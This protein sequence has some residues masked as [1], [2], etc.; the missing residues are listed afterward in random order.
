MDVA[1]LVVVALG[2]L[3]VPGLVHRVVLGLGATD[4]HEV[5][6]L[7]DR[8]SVCGRVWNRDAAGREFSRAEIRTRSGVEPTLV[9]PLPFAPCP[10]GPCAQTGNG[11]CDT[12]V[13]VRV[14]SDAYVDYS[15]SGGP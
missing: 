13:Y 2:L 8:I 9:D 1:A 7:P 14:G 11:S 6:S 10:R 4:I 5:A 15:L 12:V 3:T